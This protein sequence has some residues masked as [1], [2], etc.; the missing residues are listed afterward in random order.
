MS[1]CQTDV[2]RGTL[3]TDGI[4]DCITVCDAQY[5]KFGLHCLKSQSNVKCWQAECNV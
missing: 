4:D 1:E 2:E 5:L 3:H